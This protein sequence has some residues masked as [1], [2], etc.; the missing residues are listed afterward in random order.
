MLR[1]NADVRQCSYFELG[2]HVITTV[3]FATVHVL[4]NSWL[5]IKKIMFV[6]L[7]QIRA[8]LRGR[9]T[10]GDKLQQHVAATDHSM[11]KGRA[12]SCSNT[13]RRQITLCAKVG[14]LVAATCR[15]DTSQRQIASC[16]VENFCENLCLRNIIFSLQQVAKKFAATKFCCSDKDFHKILQY[17]RSDLCSDLNPSS[18]SKMCGTVVIDSVTLFW[19]EAYML[20]CLGFVSNWKMTQI[21]SNLLLFILALLS[22]AFPI[23]ALRGSS[24]AGAPR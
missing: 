9:Y 8:A 5:E 11:C 12:T 2:L 18:T 7:F 4:L 17:T 14:R 10:L 1:K 19:E 15:G 16:V 6:C 20:T 21:V 24:T 23:T 13:S 22:S 3:H